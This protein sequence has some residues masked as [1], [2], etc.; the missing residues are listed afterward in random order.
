MTC[1]PGLIGAEVLENRRAGLVGVADD[2]PALAVHR[3]VVGRDGRAGGVLDVRA[4]ADAAVE[5][6]LGGEVGQRLAERLGVDVE[7]LGQLP[8][9][10]QLA[11]QL[12]AGDGGAEL[13][14][15]ALELVAEL[16]LPIAWR[17]LC[18]AGIGCVF[19]RVLPPLTGSAIDPVGALNA[20]EPRSCAFDRTRP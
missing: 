12:A 10:G 3:C 20:R 11:A 4:A 1:A 9:A 15:Q 8:L 16:P 5:H 2:Q 6:A 18:A 14:A 17:R 13:L 7:P 19:H